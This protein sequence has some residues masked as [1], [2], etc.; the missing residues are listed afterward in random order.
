MP[1]IPQLPPLV[2]PIIHLGGYRLSTLTAQLD[3]VT[4]AVRDALDCLR[5]AAPN[6]WNYYLEMGRLQR[7]EDQHRI[8]IQILTAVL[9]SL[10]AE[11]LALLEEHGQ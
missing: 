11:H 3:T 6:G 8:R 9:E 5:D 1:L 7:A 2:T 4:E 10:E